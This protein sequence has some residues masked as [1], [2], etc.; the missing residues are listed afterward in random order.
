MIDIVYLDC[1]SP[2]T[3]YS[4]VLWHRTKPLDPR[5]L[6]WVFSD[7]AGHGS[8]DDGTPVLRNEFREPLFF[9]IS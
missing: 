5:W 8:C 9:S 1:Q 4:P 6:K 3:I 7:S 2:E